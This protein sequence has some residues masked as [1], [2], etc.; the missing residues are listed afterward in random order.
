MVVR[1]RHTRS[2]TGNRRSHH[3]VKN[4]R[5]SKDESGTPHLRHRMN[6]KT[7]KYRGRDVVDV[8][9]KASKKAAKK[10]AKSSDSKK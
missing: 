1:M 5:V 4:V 7:G 6:P 2:H 10:K 3:K 8:I 9:G